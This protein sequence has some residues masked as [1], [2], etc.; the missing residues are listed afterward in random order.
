M[1]N[2]GHGTMGA[3]A[4]KA[5]GMASK[6]RATGRSD[7]AELGP[8]GVGAEAATAGDPL[9]QRATRGRSSS[10]SP[11]GESL[12]EHEVHER[13]WRDRPRRA[14]SRS[15]P[16][17]ARA[18]AAA[19]A[20][21]S[22]S[23]PASDTRSPPRATPACCCCSPL[24]GRRPPG[25]DGDPREALHPPPRRQALGVKGP[26]LRPAPASAARAAAPRRGRRRRCARCP[27]RRRQG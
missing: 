21:W 1:K 2:P 7:R 19:P 17:P 16:A 3:S 8:Q 25:R 6:R 26:R 11:A 15:A 27:W 23:S 13:A 12:A 4:S 20:S 10:T 18:P 5:K 14:R 24:A 9:L 22:S